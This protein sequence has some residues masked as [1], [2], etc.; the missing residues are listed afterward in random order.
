MTLEEYCRESEGKP[1]LWGESD[2]AMWAARWWQIK[3]GERLCLPPYSSEREA[4]E[5]IN[6]AGGLVELISS[7]IGLP[8]IEQI[9]DYPIETIQ[10]DIM[11]VRARADIT[12][13]SLGNAYAVA[14]TA[15][16]VKIFLC[17]PKLVK[18][19]WSI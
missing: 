16:G 3:R 19:A 1:F 2:C 10:G 8:T 12:A 15:M 13:I 4:Q 7:Q 17:R 14:R 6:K 5:K 9:N 11:V 18:A